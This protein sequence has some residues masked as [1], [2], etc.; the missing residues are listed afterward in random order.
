MNLSVRELELLR[1]RLRD[2]LNFTVQEQGRERVCVI[3]D[4]SSSQFFRVGLEEYQFF[5]SLDGTQTVAAIIARLARDRSGETF[6]EHEA[7][8]MLRWLKDH[9]LLAVESDRATGKGE[10]SQ[11]AWAGAVKWMNPL[12]VRIPLAQPDRLFAMLARALKPFLGWFGFLHGCASCS[13][14]RRKSRWNGDGSRAASTGSSRGT[15]GCGS[16]SCGSG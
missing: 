11:R 6:T 15:T 9:H 2:G 7:L 14:V 4:P 16:A 13:Q 3:E 12:I 10:E 8:Q 5:R 1:P